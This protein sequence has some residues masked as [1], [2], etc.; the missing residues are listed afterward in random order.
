MNFGETLAFLR[1]QK[2]QSQKD[3]ADSLGISKGAVGMWE[4][5]KR[6]P[7]LEMLEKIADYYNVST[8]YLLG[9]DS[10][11]AISMHSSELTTQESKLLHYFRESQK[12]LSLK[13]IEF[14]NITDFF[15]EA[16][17][18]SS[19]E[20][21]LLSYYDQLSLIDKRWIMGQII[22]LIKKAEEQKGIILK[23]Q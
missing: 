9:R 12:N 2:K 14:G 11:D 18:L 4:T 5:N 16:Q 1:K 3:F 8:D 13:S 6:Q 21:E 10:I 7:D 23:A 22:D 20:K 15:P 17:F 19:E